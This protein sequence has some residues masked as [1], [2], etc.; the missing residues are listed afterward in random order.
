M[1]RYEE[2]YSLFHSIFRLPE[3][4]PMHFVPGNHDLPLGPPSKWFS[5]HARDRYETHFSEPNSVLSVANHSFVLLDAV[6]MVEEDYRRYAS[7]MQFGE[8]DGLE[9]G[10]IEFVKELG[11]GKLI[12]PG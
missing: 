1:G 2:Y 4:T 7:E 10:V 9:G 8:W 11:E 6:G 3:T 12:S 5:P